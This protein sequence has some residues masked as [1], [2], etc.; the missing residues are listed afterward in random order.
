MNSDLVEKINQQINKELNAYYQY[1][2]LYTYYSKHNVALHNIANYFKKESEEELKHAQK[3]IDYLNDRLQN[4]TFNNINAN[5]LTGEN[6][7][8]EIFQHVL[9]LENDI[10]ASLLSL[11]S[12]GSNDQ[13]F[14]HFIEEFLDEQVKSIKELNDHVTTLKR[15]TT[16]YH[17]YEFNKSFQ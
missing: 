17:L 8:L 10:N 16:P 13:H 5:S 12:H 2:Q 9:N 15:F 11:A 14:S 4:V 6:T 3:L 1:L 7:T